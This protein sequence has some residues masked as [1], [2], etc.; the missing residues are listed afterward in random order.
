MLLL[1][2]YLPGHASPPTL[3]QGTPT[4]RGSTGSTGRGDQQCLAD[5]RRGA[6]DGAR[7]EGLGREY[8]LAAWYIL[9]RV[10]CDS[11]S[12]S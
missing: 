1:L 7:A 10:S 6:Q 12:S 2:V 8:G 5:V 3:D 4:T 9:S 11:A